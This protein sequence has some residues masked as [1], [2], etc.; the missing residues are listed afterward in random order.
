MNK[1]YKLVLSTVV[2]GLALT[3]CNK[4]DDQPKEKG[5]FENGIFISNAGT[6]NSS[7]A[8]VSFIG[9]D[10]KVQQGIFESVNGRKV[11]DVLQSITIEDDKAYLVVNNS[12]KVEVVNANTFKEE[13]VIADLKSP[14]QI[15]EAEGNLYLTQWNGWGEK[16]S[17][18]IIDP[19]SFQIK[20]T[21]EVGNAPEGLIEVG[22]EVWVANS[23]SNSIS[24]IDINTGKVT[25]TISISTAEAP[26]QM[27]LDAEGDVWILCSGNV[28][29]DANWN[30]TGNTP[31]YL[32]EIN[33]SNKEVKDEVKLSDDQHFSMLTVNDAGSLMYYG[34][35]F[36]VKG[37]YSI[38]TVSPSVRTPIIDEYFYGFGVY[39]DDFIYGTMAPNFTS[40]GS[41]KKYDP[42]GKE[43]STYEVGIG[44]N[45]VVFNY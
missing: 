30:P 42:T 41:V 1:F 32:V 44:P 15:I 7:N 11:G 8:S 37:I 13:G 10:G 17:V 34:G 39:N 40:N 36:G 5:A 21:V 3:S 38:F 14:R 6:F 35:G 45:G 4:D 2:V 19:V 16:G 26:K 9:A 29:Y 28:L 33:P 12:N 20:S 22:N 24:I 18:K 23:T 25:S 31:S 43:I 27:I